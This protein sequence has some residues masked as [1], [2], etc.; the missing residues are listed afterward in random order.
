DGAA[1]DT[2]VF[3]D[4]QL[5]VYGTPAPVAPA[6]SGIEPSTLSYVAGQ[7][8]LVVTQALAV[9]DSDSANLN[10]ATVTISAGYA[11][12][13]DFLRFT[14]Q[15]GISGTF[16]AGVLTLTGTATVAQYQA[17]LRS[18]QYENTAGSPTTGTRTITFRVTD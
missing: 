3:Q 9:A 4:W 18:V 16:N 8:Q 10:G 14:N 15:N 1:V 11:A 13:Q 2:G 5:R 17:A 7:G 6:L 12:G